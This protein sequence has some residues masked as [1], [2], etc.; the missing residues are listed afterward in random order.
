[1]LFATISCTR[2]AD[3]DPGSEILPTILQDGNC[4][5]RSAR[6]LYRMEFRSRNQARAASQRIIQGVLPHCP[7]SDETGERHPAQRP[8]M[9]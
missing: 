2:R 7:T 3:A 5:G 6:I 4:S 1:M 8:A 9:C